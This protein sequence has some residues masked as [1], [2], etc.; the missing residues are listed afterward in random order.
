M[1]GNSDGQSCV[2]ASRCSQSAPD[3]VFC[4]SIK[5][6]SDTAASS[7][8]GVQNWRL[9]MLSLSVDKVF[10][11]TMFFGHSFPCLDAQKQWLSLSVQEGCQVQLS[12][13]ALVSDMTVPDCPGVQVWKTVALRRIVGLDWL[14]V[15]R[16]GIGHICL[17]IGVQNS[18]TNK[19][20]LS[21]EN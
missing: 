6:T 10:R 3:T 7:F 13:A 17:L 20:F 8:P 2:L 16:K 11:T 15:S 1:F 12:F 4:W 21:V 5:R 9:T 18:V 19:F 14:L